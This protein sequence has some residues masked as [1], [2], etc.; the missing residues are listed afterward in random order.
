MSEDRS[1]NTKN[2]TKKIEQGEKY[3][4]EWNEIKKIRHESGRCPVIKEGEIWWCAMGENVGVEI[5]GKHESFSRPVL[6]LKK[7]SRFGFMGIPLT[8]QEHEGD[9]YVSFIF[10]DKKQTAALA[11]ARVM[12]VSRLYKRMGTIPDSDLKNVRTGFG[13]LYLGL[14]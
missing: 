10:R 8:S 5:N 11:Q 3:F 4:D 12:S 14:E 1:N 7:L 13:V 9:W 6:V 2:I